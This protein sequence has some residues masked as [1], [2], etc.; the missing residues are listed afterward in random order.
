MG[1]TVAGVA[2]VDNLAQSGVIANFVSATAAGGSCPPSPT[3]QTIICN[4]GVLNGGASTTVS[5]VLTPTTAGTLGNSG[6]V[7]V[8]GST[9][10]ASASASLKV[11]S[12]T[13]GVEPASQTVAAGNPATYTPTLTPQ[14]TGGTYS[15]SISLACPSG[16][17]QGVS[18]TFST[19]P[20]TLQN[21]SASSVTLTMDT[22]ARTTTTA[23][24]RHGGIVYA[25]WLPIGGLTLFGVGLGGPWN[26]KR[27]VAGGLLVLLVVMLIALQPACSHSSSTTISQGTPAGTYSIA[28]TATS[29]T[30]SQTKFVQ[31]VVQ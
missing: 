24:N 1:D 4:V 27:R 20:V 6:T 17:P 18:C 13:L 22:T 28:V 31:L 5:V 2:F 23:S 30:F 11:A 14:G 15:A 8:A 21:Q 29:G 26:R 10:T 12:Y 7:I 16:L 25:M 9:F 3:N 19:S